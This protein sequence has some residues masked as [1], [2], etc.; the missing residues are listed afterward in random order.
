MYNQYRAPNPDEEN[1]FPSPESYSSQNLKASVVEAGETA[2]DGHLDGRDP[3]GFLTAVSILSPVES[4]FEQ[5][6]LLYQHLGSNILPNAEVEE[7]GAFETFQGVMIPHESSFSTTGS[8][9]AQN[10]SGGTL[11][12]KDHTQ[13]IRKFVGSYDSKEN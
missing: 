10:L 7:G 9:P 8:M 1:P 3:Q 13:D 5:T 6:V 12:N 11:R 4:Q 2:L